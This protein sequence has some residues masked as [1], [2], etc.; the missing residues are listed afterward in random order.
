MSFVSS[1]HNKST[2]SAKISFLSGTEKQRIQKSVLHEL[3]LFYGN[4][5]DKMHF[6]RQTF[7]KSFQLKSYPLINHN[8][9]LVGSFKFIRGQPCAHFNY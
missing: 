2:F 5:F 1:F 9:N 4:A 7:L 8:I 6:L 3:N